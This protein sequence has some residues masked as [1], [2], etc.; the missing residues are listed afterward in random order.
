MPQFTP[1]SRGLTIQGL[2]G[3]REG[4]IEGPPA[5]R[6]ALVSGETALTE[7][8]YG[9]PLRISLSFQ[10]S[11]G[12]AYRLWA[13]WMRAVQDWEPRFGPLVT[14]C[15][16]LSAAQRGRPFLVVARA[17]GRWDLPDRFLPD[18]AWLLQERDPLGTPEGR[19]LIHATPPAMPLGESLSS[20]VGWY[21]ETMR[22]SG[23]GRFPV[24]CLFVRSGRQSVEWDVPFPASVHVVR[25]RKESRGSRDQSPTLRILL[26]QGL[27]AKAR[28]NGPLLWGAWRSETQQE[29]FLTLGYRAGAAIHGT[30]SVQLPQEEATRSQFHA[31]LVRARGGEPVP[32][33]VSDGLLG[34]G[35]RSI[36]RNLEGSNE[37]RRVM[38]QPYADLLRILPREGM[39]L[40]DAAS[41]PEPE[42]LGPGPA[43]IKAQADLD[44]RGLPPQGVWR[45]LQRSREALMVLSNTRARRHSDGSLTSRPARE[46]YFGKTNAA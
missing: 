30:V 29:R 31:D 10:K 20:A 39:T 41:V 44:T 46:G 42:P 15:F 26:E 17:E 9:Q 32:R 21:L 18:L 4:L 27:L 7:G 2:S 12:T 28:W 19:L 23:Q 37:L 35:L 8:G 24:G 36:A 40:F 11:G 25:P 22:P 5:L 38:E 16:R 43:N 13:F 6:S 34:R 3:I 45:E 14:W 33:T 1:S